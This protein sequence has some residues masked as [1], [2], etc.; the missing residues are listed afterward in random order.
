MI[1][2]E[3]HIGSFYFTGFSSN[4]DEDR[5]LKHLFDHEKHNLMTSPVANINETIGVVVSIGIK[6]IIALVIGLF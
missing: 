1:R 3:E 6:K 4:P 5:L 2:V